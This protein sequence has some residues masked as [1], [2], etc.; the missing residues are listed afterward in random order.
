M[1]PSGPGARSNR[2]SDVLRPAEA[3]KGV[4]YH[5]FP[6]GR[7]QQVIEAIERAAEPM[8]QALRQL[9]A[10]HP[11]PVDALAAWLDGAE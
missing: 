4:L 1:P 5:H 8:G 6:G 11:H 7:Q 10:I 3:P 9:V 2:V